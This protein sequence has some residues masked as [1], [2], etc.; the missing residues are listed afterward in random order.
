[1]KFKI[2]IDQADAERRLSKQA[3]NNSKYQNSPIQLFNPIAIRSVLESLQMLWSPIILDTS[4][5]IL[6]TSYIILLKSKNRPRMFWINPISFWNNPIV[7]A[8]TNYNYCL[9][10]PNC[11]WSK[12]KDCKEWHF[13]RFN[14]LSI[15]FKTKFKFTCIKYFF[16]IRIVIKTIVS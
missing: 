3:L 1:M 9:R 16:L 13:P 12:W 14:L 5:I 6:D 11:D 10:A 4:Y 2:E 8:M 15:Y 7:K